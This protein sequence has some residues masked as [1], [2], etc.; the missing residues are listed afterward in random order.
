MYVS[1]DICERY[2]F[3][4]TKISS[5]KNWYKLTAVKDVRINYY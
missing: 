2:L 5:V 1:G 4:L 3:V